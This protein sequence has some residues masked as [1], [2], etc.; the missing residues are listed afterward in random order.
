M[1]ILADDDM[2]V[3]GNAAR[4]MLPISRARAGCI[5]NPSDVVFY[6]RSRGWRRSALTDDRADP[7]RSG[8][9]TGALSSLASISSAWSFPQ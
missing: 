8:E 3:H 5:A 6:A 2:I 4:S 1:A 9:R 7:G